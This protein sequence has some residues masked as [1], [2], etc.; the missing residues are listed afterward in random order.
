MTVIVVAFLAGVVDAARRARQDPVSVFFAPATPGRYIKRQ[1]LR[2]GP[3]TDH[4]AVD[5]VFSHAER[6]APFRRSAPALRP[7]PSSSDACRG[8]PLTH[9]L[10]L[11]RA[12]I[13]SSEAR[14]HEIRV[15]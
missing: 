7:I 14:E 10:G 12:A 13:K 3:A 5:W 4:V 11:K 9:E 8:H 1:C 15:E 2:A 6:A